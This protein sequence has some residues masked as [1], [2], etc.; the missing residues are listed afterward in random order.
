MSSK[1]IVFTIKN[2]TMNYL[3]IVVSEDQKKVPVSLTIQE[4]KMLHNALVDLLDEYPEMI[5]YAKL[6]KVLE[7]YILK[8]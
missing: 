1:T 7:A 5:G 2:K 6:R 4:L 3:S 8:P